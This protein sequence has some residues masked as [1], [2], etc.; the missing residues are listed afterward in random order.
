MVRLMCGAK[1]MD[2]RRTDDLMEMLG[3]EES[4]NSVRWYG[5]VLRKD[6]FHPLRKAL[7]FEMDGR[8]RRGRPKKM[9]KNQV[10][11]ELRKAGLRKED[12]PNRLRWRGG[13]RAIAARVR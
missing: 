8:R 5:H 10:E 1:L 13:V 2:R 7:D 11:E 12:A 3:L 6:E 9:W 4:A